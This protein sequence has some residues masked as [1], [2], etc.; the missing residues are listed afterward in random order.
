MSDNF[1]RVPTRS[2]FSMEFFYFDLPDYLADDIFVANHLRPRFFEEYELPDCEYHIIRCRV[3]RREGHVFYFCMNELARKMRLCGHADYDDYCAEFMR[4]LD[5]GLEIALG[6]DAPEEQSS[7]DYELLRSQAEN[8]I[9][10][11]RRVQER[12]PDVFAELEEHFDGL[13]GYAPGGDEP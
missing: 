3:S 4:K 11:L 5:E 10:Y 1:I 9:L 8:L 7:T 2:P 12:Y 6:D 13:P